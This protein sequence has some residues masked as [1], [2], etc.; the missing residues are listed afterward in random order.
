MATNDL[1]STYR[2]FV[3]PVDSAPRLLERIEAAIMN[4][5]YISTGPTSMIPDRGMALAPRWPD[6]PPILVRSMAPVLLH[7]LPNEF[8]V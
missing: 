1:L 4:A 3:A 5:L 7:G 8:E 2:V 6:E